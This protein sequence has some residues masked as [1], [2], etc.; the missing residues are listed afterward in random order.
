M[1]GRPK[2][3]AKPDKK[4]KKPIPADLMAEIQAAYPDAKWLA[5]IL[6]RDNRGEIG[7]YLKDNIRE[8]AYTRKELTEALDPIKGAKILRILAQQDARAAV[9]RKWRD[10]MYPDQGQSED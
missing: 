8:G 1:L 2:P 6:Q 3:E 5:G 4:E 9:A 10:F 7:G